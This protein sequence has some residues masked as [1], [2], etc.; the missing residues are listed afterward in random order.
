V[1]DPRDPDGVVTPE[2][3]AL[4]VISCEAC[5]GFVGRCDPTRVLIHPAVR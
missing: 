4:R 5:G 2:P 1:P 3:P